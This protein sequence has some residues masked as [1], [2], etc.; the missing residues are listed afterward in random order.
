MELHFFI[1][2]ENILF[3]CSLLINFLQNESM[4]NIVD[5]LNTVYL[6]FVEAIANLIEAKSASDCEVTPAT[7]AA[8]ENLKLRWKLYRVACDQAEGFVESLKLRICFECLVDEATCSV[9][10]NSGVQPISA[11]R[12]EQMSKTV[13][14]LVVELPNG[15]EFVGSSSVGFDA[16][17]HEDS[18][19]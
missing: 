15:S 5:A 19:Q 4:D 11:V 8:L 7:D 9:V 2:L 13:R 6:D 14:S 16:R 17:F 10:G 18:T 1:S 3:V 12:L